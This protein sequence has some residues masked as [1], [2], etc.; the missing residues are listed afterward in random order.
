MRVAAPANT[1]ARAIA[2]LRGI[3]AFGDTLVA[4]GEPA[5]VAVASNWGMALELY[6]AGYERVALCECGYLGN[7]NYWCS[8][9]LDGLNGRGIHVEGPERPPPALEPWRGAREGYAL[10]LGQIPE[11]W[12]VRVALK[13]RPYADWMRE[14]TLVLERYGFTV[15][16][17]PHPEVSMRDLTLTKQPPS[18]REE[19]DGARIAVTLNSTAAIEAICMGVPTVTWDRRGCMAGAVSSECG[20]LW[21]KDEPPHR[22]AWVNRLARL[23]WNMEELADGS[24]WRAMRG[25]MLQC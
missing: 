13:D 23:Q 6:K 4:L 17:R 5:P 18:L 21:L 3:S 22:R 20:G 11:D 14:A 10:L 2:L 12:A 15:R 19:L 1:K 8:L 25:G 16:Y 9:S 24:A 7:R